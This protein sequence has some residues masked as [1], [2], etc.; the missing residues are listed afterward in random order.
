M[1]RDAI[2]RQYDVQKNSITLTCEG[3]GGYRPGVITFEAKPGKS[4]DLD[5]IRES[6]TATR[7]S[8]GTSMRVDY[9]EITATGSFDTSDKAIVLNVFGTKQ[10]FVLG[11]DPGAKGALQKLR[12]ALAR[13]DKV[14]S[15][16]GR[17]PG[18]SGTFPTVLKALAKAADQGPAQLLVT[19]FEISKK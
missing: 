5:K 12:D 13:G 17:V 1:A 7:L 16:S 3:T 4:I 11:E 15:V 9:L 19:G 14:A 8:G 18:W 2:S 10:Q 6:I